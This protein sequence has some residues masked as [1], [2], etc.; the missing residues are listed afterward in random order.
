MFFNSFAIFKDIWG[1]G[2]GMDGQ[3]IVVKVKITQMNL[4]F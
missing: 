1:D 2:D 4:K 3:H